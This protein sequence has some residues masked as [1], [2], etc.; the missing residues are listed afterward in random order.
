MWC[1]PS[2]VFACFFVATIS[3]NV[4]RNNIEL[5]SKYFTFFDN[6]DY[7][8]NKKKKRWPY[9]HSSHFNTLYMLHNNKIKISHDRAYCWIQFKIDYF[10][11]PFHSIHPSSV[12]F[13]LNY[14]YRVKCEC[15]ERLLCCKALATISYD[16]DLYF[17]MIEL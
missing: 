14:S 7:N 17:N 3:K 12:E 16:F 8:V 10:I 1:S 9:F 5:Y 15:V 4:S 13:N 2:A 6:I 11:P